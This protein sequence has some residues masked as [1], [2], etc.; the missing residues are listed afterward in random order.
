MTTPLKYIYDE[1]YGKVIGG[2]VGNFRST[3]YWIENDTER[4]IGI[5]FDDDLIADSSEEAV[6]K[7][8]KAKS[9]KESTS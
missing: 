5:G 6:S 3:I 2:A 9:K 8:N 7:Y 1:F 4:S